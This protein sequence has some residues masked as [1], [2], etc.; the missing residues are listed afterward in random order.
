MERGYIQSAEL[1][2]AESRSRTIDALWTLSVLTSA[3]SDF[4]DEDDY[5]PFTN[6]YACTSKY[7]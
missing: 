4:I 5:V 1:S 6:V 3:T 2:P 7:R